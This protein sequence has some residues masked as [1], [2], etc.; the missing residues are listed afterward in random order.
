MGRWS[1]NAGSNNLIKKT[2]FTVLYFTCLFLK[3]FRVK[4]YRNLT[5]GGGEIFPYHSE[6]FPLAENLELLFCSTAFVDKI[7]RGNV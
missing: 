3:M 7:I 1:L 2:G 4:K 6:Y 5:W